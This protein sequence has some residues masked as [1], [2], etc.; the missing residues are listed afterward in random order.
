MA[1]RRFVPRG[2]TRPGRPFLAGHEVELLVDGGPFFR[3][4]IEAIE[5]ARR[6]IYLETY[7]LR[8]DETGWRIAR[9]LAARA[10]DG[11]EV[12]ICYDAYGSEGLSSSF[13]RFL[14]EAGVKRL[15]FRPLS[16]LR[17]SMPW[18]RRNHRKLVL[19]DGEVGIV[20]GL[21]LSDDYAA[22]ES[23]GKGWRDTAVRV[24]GPAVHKLESLFRR[25]WRTEGGPAL[26]SSPTTR[27]QPM[28]GGVAVRFFANFARGERAMIRRAYEAAIMGAHDHIRIT[29]AYFFPHRALRRA[30]ERAARRGVKVQLILAGES[31]VRPAIYAARSLYARLLRAGV[32]V[33]EWH[34]RV[35]HAK[36]AV[37]DGEWST[38]GSS[39]LDPFSSFVNLELNAGIFSR[40]FGVKMNEQFEVDLA[41]CRRIELEQWRARPWT[42]RLLEM[43]FRWVTKRY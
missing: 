39:N 2:R 22:P 33:Y 27:L 40:R 30:L 35:L 16:I 10:Q 37:I 20:G 3:R 38:I 7:I 42:Q 31:D 5:A 36:T 29:N 19:V 18:S 41:K 4:V 26:V 14:D 23:G 8:S 34:E 25:L 1:L 24:R 11:V 17:R 13:V 43:A 12:A 32:E 9:A 21:N 28:P 15:P 6:Y